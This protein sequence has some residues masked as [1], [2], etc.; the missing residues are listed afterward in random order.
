M[1]SPLLCFSVFL[2]AVGCS[3]PVYQPVPLV[4][5]PRRSGSEGLYFY[6]TG[7]VKRPGP[8][9]FLGETSAVRAIAAADGFT[10]KADPKRIEIRRRDGTIVRLNYNEIAKIETN[11]PSIYPGDT[12]EVKKRRLLW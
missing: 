7:E 6:V 9:P 1:K 8:E 3:A 4:D 10:A 5:E 2:L 11:A 12:V